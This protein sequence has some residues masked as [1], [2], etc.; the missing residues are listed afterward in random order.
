ME[1]KHAQQIADLINDRNRLVRAYD[2]STVLQNAANIIYE[3][4]DEK[5]VACIE[6]KRVQWYQWEVYHLCVEKSHENQGLGSSMIHKAET[7]AIAGGARIMQCTIRVGNESSEATFKKNGYHQ[8]S[9][10]YYP[11]SGNDVF[12]WQKVVSI[13]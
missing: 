8:T 3:L 1:S 12:V 6:V 11:N 2:V 9:K 10:F 7:R 4:E 13:K 5:V